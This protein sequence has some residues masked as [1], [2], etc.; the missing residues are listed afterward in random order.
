MGTGEHDSI[1][2]DEG[3][4]LAVE[5]LVGHNVERATLGLQPVGEVQVGV[6]LV[7]SA[8]QGEVVLGTHVD[9]RP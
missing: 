6:E 7:R 4:A 3:D 1:V 2:L 5:V 9:D 8:D